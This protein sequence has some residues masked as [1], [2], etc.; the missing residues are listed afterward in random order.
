[1]Y[2]YLG[3]KLQGGNKEE[4]TTYTTLITLVQRCPGEGWEGPMI[5]PK[6]NRKKRTKEKRATVCKPKEARAHEKNEEEKYQL[7]KTLYGTMTKK[8]ALVQSQ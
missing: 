1:M 2:W 3:Y 6:E 4:K 8:N 5:N 7:P